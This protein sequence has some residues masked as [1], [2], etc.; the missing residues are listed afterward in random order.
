MKRNHYLIAYMDDKQK[1]LESLTQADLMSII[2]YGLR[3]SN[4]PAGVTVEDI[5]YVIQ[6]NPL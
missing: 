4:A 6:S 3:D 2:K 1:Y 5:Y